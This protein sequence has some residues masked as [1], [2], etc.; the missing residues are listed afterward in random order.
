IKFFSAEYGPLQ[1]EINDVVWALPNNQGIGTFNWAPTTRGDWNTG[2]DLLRRSGTTYQEQP[3]LAL[4]DLM[5][6][7]Y[8]SR[9]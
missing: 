4:Y 2:H 8:A 5:K 1:R 3:D 9:L 7:A 6:V